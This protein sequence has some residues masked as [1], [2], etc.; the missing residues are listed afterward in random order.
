MVSRVLDQQ[1][2]LILSRRDVS[3]LSL[4]HCISVNNAAFS[5]AKGTVVYI[6]LT[7]LYKHTYNNSLK[8]IMP[9]KY[10]RTITNKKELHFYI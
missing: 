3:K 2:I 6:N 8:Y 4:K 7:Q 10:R 5:P 9:G 1:S